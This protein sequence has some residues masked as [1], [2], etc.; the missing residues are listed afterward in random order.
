MSNITSPRTRRLARDLL[1]ITAALADRIKLLSG[2]Y[3]VEPGIINFLSEFDPSPNWKYL[4]WLVRQ[5]KINGNELLF[6]RNQIRDCLNLFDNMKKSRRVQEYYQASADIQDY[7]IQDLY[8]LNERFLLDPYDSKRKQR[9][10]AKQTG[11]K[12]IYDQG[13]IKIIQVGGPGADPVMATQAACIYAW[14]TKWCTSRPETATGYLTSGAL[15]VIFR[16]GKKVALFHA[17]RGD[18]KDPEDRE[19]EPAENIDLIEAI[20]RAPIPD[21][22]SYTVSRWLEVMPVDLWREWTLVV[23][24]PARIGRLEVDPSLVNRVFKEQ[25]PDMS[26][27]DVSIT[28]PLYEKLKLNYRLWFSSSDYIDKI[29]NILESDY[30]PPPILGQFGDKDKLYVF[31]GEEHLIAALLAGR[32][33]LPCYVVRHG[34][35]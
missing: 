26:L 25:Y 29:R 32:T 22:N 14:N 19:I 16:D 12:T 31:E 9:D 4:E 20:L 2:K 24:K 1:R 5:F 17:S 34:S 7:T 3:Q 28:G 11:A 15:Y 13:H 21:L 18:L 23:V 35:D 33:R 8:N 27:E 6:A 30:I 10:Q